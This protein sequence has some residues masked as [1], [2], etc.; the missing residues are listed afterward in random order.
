MELYKELLCGGVLV[1]AG[2]NQTASGMKLT[3]GGRPSF[4]RPPARNPEPPTLVRMAGDPSQLAR[5]S[6]GTL[7][8]DRGVDAPAPKGVNFAPTARDIQQFEPA[9]A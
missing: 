7:G 1:V 4:T 8:G 5:T 6:F 3:I 2:R 9:D